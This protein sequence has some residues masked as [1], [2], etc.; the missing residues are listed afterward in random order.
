MNPHIESL[1]C[2]LKD[3]IA[4]LLGSMGDKALKEREEAWEAERM[5]RKLLKILEGRQSN[6]A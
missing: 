2:Y 5:F 1:R 6:D 3:N 4:H